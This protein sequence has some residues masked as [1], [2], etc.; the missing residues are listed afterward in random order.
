MFG[1]LVMTTKHSTVHHLNRAVDGRK[2]KKRRQGRLDVG[3][4]RVLQRKER[5]PTPGDTVKTPGGNKYKLDVPYMIAYRTLNDEI[6]EDK[7]RSLKNFHLIVPYL[8]AMRKLNPLPVIGYTKDDALDNIIDIHFSPAISNE[9]LHFVRP[10]ISLDVAH[11][12]SKYKG[13]LYIASVLSGGDNIYPIS[14]MIF[15][16]N[17]NCRTWTKML[18]LLKQA[19]PI[20]CEQGFPCGR[21]NEK[22]AGMTQ[23]LFISN[24][25]KGLKPAL[26]EVFPDN[27]EMSCAKHIET[28]MT[29][30]FGRLCGRHVM[31]MAKTCFQRYYDQVLDVIQQ[32][33]P[34]AAEYIKDIS[35]NGILL[36]NLQWTH[37]NQ[38]LPPRIGI[39]TSN[40]SKS[41]NSM[42]NSAH[43]L[44]WM[45]ALK[46]WST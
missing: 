19:C 9:I 22:Y 16:G 4:V 21:S 32:N 42:F 13:M 3:V 33:K 1:L 29:Q 7:K 20:I 27:Y 31:A 24:R 34:R 12:R 45:D 23:F 28:N 17:E 2:L 46:K 37:S 11:L 40:T 39:V 38:T 41:D 44:P 15:S 10:V 25:D 14:L 5:A 43:D 6:V 8:E 18:C 30:R 36:N 26:K 35:R